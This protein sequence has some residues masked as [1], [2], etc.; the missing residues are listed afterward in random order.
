M[1]VTIEKLAPTGEGIARTPEGVGFIAGALPGEQVEAE[2]EELRKNFWKGRSLRVLV[3]SPARIAGP[4]AACA[5]CDWAYFEPRAALQAKRELFLETM[6]RIGGQEPEIF[7][8]LPAA[9]SAA[10]YRLRHRFHVS[11]S[12]PGVVIGYFAP[13]THRV[14]PITDCEAVSGETLELLPRV[15]D[16]I[17][18]S[19]A[20]V[21][22]VALLETRDSGRH[23]GRVLLDP[24]AAAQKSRLLTL[25][26]PLMAGVRLEVEHRGE[27]SERGAAFLTLTAGGRPFPISVDSFFQ[28]NRSLVDRLYE[29]VRDLARLAAP[30]TALDAFG[31][32]GFF[33][34][35]LLD[36][37]HT[38]TTVEGNRA[39]VRDGERART[40]WPDGERWSIV[41]SDVASFVAREGSSFRLAVVDP[42][43]AG[44][45]QELAALLARRVSRR[46][47]YVSCEPATLARDLPAIRS[48]GFEII[49]AR[50]YDLFAGTH[51][52]EAV[53]ALERRESS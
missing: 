43:R 34:G 20:S 17:A 50:L 16:A 39:G 46:L 38:V 4:H 22:T 9:P 41:R 18:R 1:R 19:G 10:R 11:G 25:L 52:I 13:R 27:P 35:A 14:E 7:G 24:S 44:L 26:S 32:G 8:A 47:I 48:E 15:R 36:A 5:G 49:A 51:R 12:G 6:R 53:V 45:G 37:G 40:L 31:G 33:A 42:P 3:P 29:D 28:T 2:V 30:G 23:I 21:T